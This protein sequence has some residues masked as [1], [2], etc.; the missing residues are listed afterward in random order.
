MEHKK[1]NILRGS[2]MAI[3]VMAVSAC[4]NFNQHSELEA[5]NEVQAVGSPFTQQLT[6]EYRDFANREMNEMFDYPDALHFARK[7]LATAAGEVVLPE[8]ISDWNLLPHHMQELGTARARLIVAFDL[9]AREIAPKEAAI[10][11]ARFDCWIEQQEENWQANDILACKSQ[12]LDAMANLEALLGPAPAKPV[13]A[14]AAVGM[15]EAIPMQPEDAMYLV[16]FDFDSSQV[17]AGGVNVLDA[18]A[19]EAKAR[20]VNKVRVVGHTDSSGSHKY[21]ERLAN[22]RA[23]VVR[24]A[25]VQRGV[26]TSLIV[27][28][29]RGETELLVDTADN[30]REP[31]NRRA[32]ISFE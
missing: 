29:G 1:M 6:V 7:G 12:Y 19:Q 24:D 20:N 3:V 28:E 32:Q 25:L 26:S 10:A 31:A 13:V 18:V 8:P 15:P 14:D 4:S 23:N 5:L 11:Q 21:N 17:G 30:V 27:V 2:L 22:K 9:G 16:F